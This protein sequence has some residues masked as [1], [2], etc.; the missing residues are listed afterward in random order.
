MQFLQLGESFRVRFNENGP[1]AARNERKR[2]RA[3]ETVVGPDVHDNA[4][5]IRRHQAAQC[6]EF[7]AMRGIAPQPVFDELPQV[8]AASFGHGNWSRQARNPPMRGAAGKKILARSR[9]AGIN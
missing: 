1:P 6:G 8:H 4:R 2:I 7:P 5:K 9:I 3:V